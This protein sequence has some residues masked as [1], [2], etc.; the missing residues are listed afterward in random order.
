[1]TDR[2]WDQIFVQGGTVPKVPFLSEEEAAKTALP[3]ST[4]LVL[5]MKH[6]QNERE[7]TRT[8]TNER[9]KADAETRMKRTLEEMTPSK[10][11]D[12]WVAAYPEGMFEDVH[13]QVLHEKLG[14][15]VRGAFVGRTY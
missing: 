3:P 11:H 14:D 1:M 2:E 13:K 7:N 15:A 8:Q 9:R 10:M 12:L 4:E 6:L 5:T